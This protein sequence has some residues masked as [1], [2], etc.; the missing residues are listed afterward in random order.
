MCCSQSL[1]AAPFWM[2]GQFKPLIIV[3]VSPLL[4][5]PNTQAPDWLRK[6]MKGHKSNAHVLM[7][8]KEMTQGNYMT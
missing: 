1:P 6:L 3:I 5:V 8:S 4:H 7:G 2:A